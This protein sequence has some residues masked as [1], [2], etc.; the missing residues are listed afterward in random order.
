MVGKERSPGEDIHMCAHMYTIMS[1]A[2]HIL[3]HTIAIFNTMSMYLSIMFTFPLK[4]TFTLQAFLS[5]KNVI[6]F[7]SRQT[8]PIMAYVHRTYG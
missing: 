3:L 4:V 1:D 2:F 8:F 5:A 7:S 6:A